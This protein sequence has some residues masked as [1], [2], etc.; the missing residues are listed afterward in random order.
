MP[1]LLKI[2]PVLLG[3][4]KHPYFYLGR[5]FPTTI[6]E[7][8]PSLNGTYFSTT[9]QVQCDPTNFKLCQIPD[10]D[11]AMVG[12]VTQ[13]ARALILY[14]FDPSEKN[15]AG[16]VLNCPLNC[17][18]LRDERFPILVRARDES[19]TIYVISDPKKEDGLGYKCSTATPPTEN[20]DPPP[21][22]EHFLPHPIRDG[23]L[24]FFL[25]CNCTLT[26]GP[27]ILL[28]SSIDC[29]SPPD[30]VTFRLTPFH[31]LDPNNT[32]TSKKMEAAQAN[33]PSPILNPDDAAR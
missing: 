32:S 4:I 18:D 8:G 33:T 29:P 23:V 26:I 28:P 3:T 2:V 16:I 14:D 7:G 15:E 22:E 5:L 21:P 27:T 6:E 10:P 13:C 30:P 11:G 25:P 24:A 17:K 9:T 12:K 1:E 31:F 19:Q 20:E